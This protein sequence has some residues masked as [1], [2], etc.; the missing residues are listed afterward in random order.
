MIRLFRRVLVCTLFAA[1]SSAWAQWFPLKQSLENSVEILRESQQELVLYHRVLQDSVVVTLAPAPEADIHGGLEFRRGSNPYRVWITTKRFWQRPLLA[2]DGGRKFFLASLTS[3]LRQPLP[4][5]APAEDHL[6]SSPPGEEAV[7]GLAHSSA[8]AA[9]DTAVTPPPVTAESVEE[10]ASEDAPQPPQP[11]AADS[12]A[13]IAEQP[14]PPAPAPTRQ[15]TPQPEPEAAHAESETNEED[16]RA[17]LYAEGLAA[18]DQEDFANALAAFEQIRAVDPAYRDVIERIRELETIQQQEQDAAHAQIWNAQMDSLYRSGRD[19]ESRADWQ[20]AIADFEEL[21]RRQPGYRDVSSR[22]ERA[23]ASLTPEKS[24]AF[25]PPQLAQ[26][27]SAP[28]LIGA[29]VAIVVLPLLSFIMFSSTTRS[30]YYLLRGNYAAAASIYEVMLARHPQREKLYLPL[31]HIYLLLGRRD[32]QALKVYNAVLR[33]NLATPNR[34]IIKEIVAKNQP[35][36]GPAAP[37]FAKLEDK[38]EPP[39]SGAD[40]QA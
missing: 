30:R 33:L 25:T 24:P 37:P 18:L 8:P 17:R 34:E 29:A 22:L 10:I 39:N 27:S 1:A 14:E 40:L 12:F 9:A 21:E 23:R 6:K 28:Y 38:P 36:K 4:E 16:W 15:R 7:R 32:E 2:E 5:A 3:S 19:H 20:R 11:V 31:A 13:G 35:A 26:Q